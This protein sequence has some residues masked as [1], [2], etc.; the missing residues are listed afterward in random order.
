MGMVELPF[1]D[2]AP[3]DV[4]MTAGADIV[5]SAGQACGTVVCS[6]RRDNNRVDFLAVVQTDAIGSQA[7]HAEKA[8]G[9]LI[10]WIPLPYSL[11]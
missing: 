7:L 9:P 8:D 4:N 3:V 5:D 11:P 1:E 2:N 6:A 10:T